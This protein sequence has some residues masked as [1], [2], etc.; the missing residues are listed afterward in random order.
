MKATRVQLEKIV[1]DC[2]AKGLTRFKCAADLKPRQ[3]ENISKHFYVQIP[4]EKIVALR[5]MSLGNSGKE[6]FVLT[7]DYLYSYDHVSDPICLEKLSEFITKDRAIYF[8][9]WGEDK[10]GFFYTGGFSKDVSSIL[11][12]FFEL[13]IVQGSPELNV[14]DLNAILSQ[15]PRFVMKND[16]K[17]EE[18]KFIKQFGKEVQEDQVVAVSTLYEVLFTTESYFYRNYTGSVK[19][20][21]RLNGLKGVYHNHGQKS[22]MALYR[23]GTQMSF[24]VPDHIIAQDILE[25]IF[26][27]IS[28][29]SSTSDAAKSR[30]K[31]NNPTYV[32]SRRA[33][34]E[35]EFFSAD[36]FSI[37]YTKYKQMRLPFGALLKMVPKLLDEFEMDELPLLYYTVGVQA[38]IY[39]D[40]Y[41]AKSYL[42]RPATVHNLTKAFYHIHRLETGDDIKEEDYRKGQWVLEGT[43]SKSEAIDEY[44]RFEKRCREAAEASPYGLD[45][46]SRGLDERLKKYSFCDYD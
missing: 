40:F 21:I 16:F 1:R 18:R 22:M 30:I 41:F 35:D 23:N 33:H 14:E 32:A 15:Y 17:K 13:S 20:S 5:D 43:D 28:D 46:I 44:I 10:N 12:A 9:H 42:Y 36:G 45:I 39:K 6:G 25:A 37:N 29:L 27:D 2:Y 34:T 38:H 3:L 31:K 11:N 26:E 7:E 4:K 19:S 24:N 8:K